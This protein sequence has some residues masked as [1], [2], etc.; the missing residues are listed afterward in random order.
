MAMRDDGDPDGRRSLFSHRDATHCLRG[1][2]RGGSTSTNTQPVPS[3]STVKM[4]SY[5]SLIRRRYHLPRAQHV[6]LDSAAPTI[7]RKPER[8]GQARALQ[9]LPGIVGR[10]HLAELT[11]RKADFVSW[12]LVCT[13]TRVMKTQTSNEEL[14]VLETSE[15][16]TATGGIDKKTQKWLDLMESGMGPNKGPIAIE[17]PLSGVKRIKK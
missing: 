15:L 3:R 17:V 2:F 1:A 16:I 9:R 7:V 4:C 14:R 6:R 8:F 11:T 12:H 10:R 5:G 13:S